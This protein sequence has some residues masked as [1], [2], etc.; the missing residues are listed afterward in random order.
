M[1]VVD[2]IKTTEQ[3]YNKFNLDFC[4]DRSSNLLSSTN[5]KANMVEWDIYR[6]ENIQKPKLVFIFLLKH[7]IYNINKIMLSI[8]F[9]GKL[10][11][12]GY[13]NVCNR[14]TFSIKV[15]SCWELMKKDKTWFLVASL[16][17]YEL[18]E[19]LIPEILQKLK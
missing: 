7:F 5:I 1:S 19:W 18:V 11:I 10:E 17:R 16:R 9:A 4:L 15:Q 13:A 8:Q 12:P 2:K 3:A 6:K 14:I